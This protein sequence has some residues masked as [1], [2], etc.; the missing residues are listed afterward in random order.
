MKQI[1]L[2]ESQLN[3]LQELVVHKLEELKNYEKDDIDTIEAYDAIAYRLDLGWVD[4]GYRS[5]RWHVD[6]FE[7]QAAILEDSNLGPFD[8]DLFPAA[9]QNMIDRHD[10]SVG[11]TWDTINWYLLAQCIKK[12]EDE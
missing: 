10:A 5:V 3:L 8:S 11:I 4:D 12:D 6:D 9:L 7:H 2:T 1:E